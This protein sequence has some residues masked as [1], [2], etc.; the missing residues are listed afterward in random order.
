[1]FKT[2]LFVDKDNKVAF[3][4]YVSLMATYNQEIKNLNNDAT[5]LI[6]L[7]KKTI[8]EKDKLITIIKKLE[9]HLLKMYEEYKDSECEENY[10]VAMQCMYIYNY[11][12]ELKGSDKE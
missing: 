8:R 5:H 9:E 4:D 10:T 11:I 1:M 2:E 6:E 7:H 12:Q 3:K